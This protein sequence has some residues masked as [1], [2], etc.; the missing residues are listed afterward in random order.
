MDKLNKDVRASL[1]VSLS[2]LGYMLSGPGLLFAFRPLIDFKTS[3]VFI[4]KFGKVCSKL[5]NGALSV[6]SLAS[7][8]L[9][10]M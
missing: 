9:F 8:S 5:V 7:E 2:I 10:V 1:F 3:S 4:S 6:S